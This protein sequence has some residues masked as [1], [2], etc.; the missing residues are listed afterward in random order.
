MRLPEMKRELSNEFDRG[1]RE[2]Y[3][4]LRVTRLFENGYGPGSVVTIGSITIVDFDE[5]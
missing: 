2:T 5:F 4:Y 3:E 1:R